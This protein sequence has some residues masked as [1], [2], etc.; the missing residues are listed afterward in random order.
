MNTSRFGVIEIEEKEIIVFTKGLLGFHEYNR[1]ILIPASED[2]SNLFYFLQSVDEES[3][4]FILINPFSVH[5][6]YEIDL[7]DKVVEKLEIESAEDVLIYTIVT[8]K[9]SLRTATTNLK[10]PIVINIKNNRGEQIILEGK[11]YP[12]KN[13][14]QIYQRNNVEIEKG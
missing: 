4:C 14:I 8:V 2:N 11:D 10:A 13:P 12:I 9:D 6:N 5:D 3:L 7:G 1:Y